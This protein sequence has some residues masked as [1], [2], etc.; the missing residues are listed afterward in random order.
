MSR[1]LLVMFWQPDIE[2]AARLSLEKKLSALKSVFNHAYNHFQ[3]Y[4]QNLHQQNATLLFIAPEHYFVDQYF[5]AYSETQKQLI[6]T[7]LTKDTALH[8]HTWHN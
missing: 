2:Q 3:Q 5:N 7:Q 1:K 6:Q 4:L 8:F